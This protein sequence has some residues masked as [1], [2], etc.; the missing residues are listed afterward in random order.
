MTR[1]MPIRVVS[2]KSFSPRPT[3][4]AARTGSFSGASSP[5]EE[6]NHRRTSRTVRPAARSSSAA[7]FSAVACRTRSSA[8]LQPSRPLSIA[9]RIST[10]PRSRIR[11]ATRRASRHHG[12]LRP[13]RSSA[14]ASIDENP[15]SWWPPVSCRRSSSSPIC[16][17]ICAWDRPSL[18]SA[19]SSAR[20]CSSTVGDATQLRAALTVNQRRSDRTDGGQKSST[21]K[22]LWNDFHGVLADVRHSAS[23][24]ADRAAAR[25]CF[26]VASQRIEA[27]AWCPIEVEYPYTV[28]VSA[29]A[30]LNTDQIRVLRGIDSALSVEPVRDV[31]AKL[32]TVDRVDL[33]PFEH[34][35]VASVLERLEAVGLTG[36]VVSSGEDAK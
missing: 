14:Y 11:R 29:P 24:W 2:K 9:V 15:S 30:G 7:S 17:R 13:H 19:S 20:S 33:G 36:L 32:R 12:L 8:M 3:V 4:R 31:F 22:S 1:P 27:V 34:H 23:C 10:R 5:S 16:R 21:P 28:S 26:Q 6:E 25:C 18:A 35:E